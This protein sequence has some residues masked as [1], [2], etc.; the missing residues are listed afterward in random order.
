MSDFFRRLSEIQKETSPEAKPE[1]KPA[2]PEATPPAENPP[3]ETP[4]AE[5]PKPE[6]P[7]EYDTG[8]FKVKAPEVN[9]DNKPEETP[10]AFFDKVAKTYGFTVKSWDEAL[11][12][13]GKLK[14]T[15]TK[16]EETEVKVKDYEGLVS[17]IPEDVKSVLADAF[18]GKDYRNTMKQ[19]ASSSVD[20]NR[21]FDSY[22]DNV[23]IKMYN[24]DLT[25]DDLEEMEEK[26][27]DRLYDLSVKQY[28][29]DR[30]VVLDRAAEF[31][32]RQKESAKML[33]TSIDNSVN[34]LKEKYPSIK[35]EY[36][37]NIRN[38][39][40]TN[41]LANLLNE[42]N[43]WKEDAAIKIAMAEYGQNI[44]DDMTKQLQAEMEKN[45]KLAAS[46]ARE[47]VIK[48]KLHDAPPKETHSADG[49]T[50]KDRVK[51]SLPFFKH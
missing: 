5:T 18:E 14:E 23:L 3:V 47:E 42:Q 39:M 4:P 25:D 49:L 12:L 17:S 13:V 40:K 11:A 10:E 9:I 50:L 20:Y 36:V 48:E 35:R 19:I 32:K 15:E 26:T 45:V 21:T 6:A 37:D 16:L 31:D 1:E 38:K 29:L 22:K 28:N 30:K 33:L 41:Y 8:F 51:N 7:T 2:A 43:V 27:K 44:I 34:K 24:P 46:S